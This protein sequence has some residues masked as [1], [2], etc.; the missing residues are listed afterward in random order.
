VFDSSHLGLLL[1]FAEATPLT[2]ARVL[3]SMQFDIDPPAPMAAADGGPGRDDS[4]QRLHGLPLV[5]ATALCCHRA[6]AELTLRGG[7]WDVA[8]WDLT[9]E[10]IALCPASLLLERLLLVFTV[11]AHSFRGA[12]ALFNLA[13]KLTHSCGQC[14]VEYS[15]AV[16]DGGDAAAAVVPFVYPC[17]L[18]PGGARAPT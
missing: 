15:T 13:T 7:P 14:D 12:A 4:E 2:Q 11:N 6:A 17:T 5:A 8:G 10:V 9:P 1:D 3:R 18:R 16:P